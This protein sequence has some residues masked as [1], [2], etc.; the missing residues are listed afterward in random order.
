MSSQAGKTRP[1]A[2]AHRRKPASA[3]LMAMLVA[4]GVMH[5]TWMAVIAVLATAQNLPGPPSTAPGLMPPR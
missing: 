1:A 4:V 5:I 2:G 3:G